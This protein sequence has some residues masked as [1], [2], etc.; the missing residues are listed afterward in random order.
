MGQVAQ[1]EDGP[2]QPSVLDDRPGEAPMAARGVESAQN[3]RGGGVAEFERAGQ[4]QQVVPV[5][6][7]QLAL[8]GFGEQSSGP[9]PLG[10]R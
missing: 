5:L 10:E 2:D 8:D 7:D 1:H 9:G 6:D 3:Q 4:A